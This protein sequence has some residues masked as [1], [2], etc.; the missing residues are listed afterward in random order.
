M[1]NGREILV[2]IEPERYDVSDTTFYGLSLLLFLRESYFLWGR[3]IE[4]EFK[5][6]CKT[7][8][9]NWQ[10]ENPDYQIPKSDVHSIYMTLGITELDKWKYDIKEWWNDL[11]DDISEWWISDFGVW[12]I[13]I[14]YKDLLGIEHTIKF[15][16]D[17]KIIAPILLGIIG[18]YFGYLF[19]KSYAIER[20]VVEAK[21]IAPI[22]KQIK[23]IEKGVKKKVKK[24][25]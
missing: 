10:I 21:A 23:K 14:P 18:I 20:G 6:W 22:G 7:Y 16:I 1:E 5:Y 11:C 15:D 24:V 2:I 13:R 25:M 17:F 9:E 3:D 19:T 8:I 4:P 12:K